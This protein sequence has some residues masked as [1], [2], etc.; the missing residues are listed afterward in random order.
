MYFIPVVTSEPQLLVAGAGPKKE[1]PPM[2]R[3]SLHTYTVRLLRPLKTTAP[4]DG[5][6]TE[7]SADTPTHQ[8]A[9]PVHGALR[10]ARAAEAKKSGLQVLYHVRFMFA[11]ALL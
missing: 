5:T 1:G 6:G 4:K 9:H 3:P 10:G 11:T 7:S 8:L 2:K